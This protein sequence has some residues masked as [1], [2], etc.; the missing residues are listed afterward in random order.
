MPFVPPQSAYPMAEGFVPEM[1]LM[2]RP[3]L[4]NPSPQIDTPAVTRQN[5]QEP[6][7]INVNGFPPPGIMGSLGD[8]FNGFNGFVGANTMG[9]FEQMGAMNQEM[10]GYRMRGMSELMGGM[11][12][13]IGE[14]HDQLGEVNEMG[15]VNNGLMEGMKR[16]VP[17]FSR[18][19]KKTMI[20]VRKQKKEKSA[21]RTAT[22]SDQLKVMKSKLR[23]PFKMYFSRQKAQIKKLNK[24]YREINK[25]KR[26]HKRSAENI[27]RKSKLRKHQVQKSKEETGSKKNSIVIHRPPIIYHPP[28]EVYHR[29]DIVVH[30]APIM[31]HRPPIVYHQPPVVVHRPAIIYH[32]PE[33]VFHQP[34]PV[35][36][37]P[38]LQSHDTWVT[39]PQIV[40]GTSTMSHSH[41]YYGI[42]NHVYGGT[43]DDCHGPH[44]SFRKQ[45]IPH[46]SRSGKNGNNTTEETKM[47]ERKKREAYIDYLTYLGTLWAPRHKRDID[48]QYSFITSSSK[49]KEHLT[50]L[51]NNDQN[52]SKRDSVDD[53]NAHIYNIGNPKM[54]RA[55]KGQESRKK[56]KDVVVNRPPIIYH[57]PPEIYH[58]P[59]I[60]VHRPPLVIHRPPIIYH[61]PPV[62]VHRPAVV[63]HQPPIVFHQP[64]P[65]VSQPLLYSHDSFMVS[66]IYYIY[67]YSKKH[68]RQKYL[69]NGIF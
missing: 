1:P 38:V 54:K 10:N 58:R 30:R 12:G 9:G 45:G 2:E 29:P 63:Y 47:K 50:Y 51:N 4:E 64:P 53:F 23:H 35:V 15:A 34:P 56:K 49:A 40:P 21:L 42:P 11:N 20:T 62:I 8:G 25:R 61:Q 22:K 60:V 68:F 52:L 67:Y 17:E 66:S 39:R 27:S 24:A 43:F 13:G 33:I 5:I 46:K 36:N 18:N 14:M 6:A 37:Q 65:A 44:C 3:M 19:V 16:Y 57:P 69:L 48:Q 26:K 32:Q 55:T 31:L 59:D 28:P 7:P 41:T